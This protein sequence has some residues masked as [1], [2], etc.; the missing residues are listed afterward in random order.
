MGLEMTELI[1]ACEEEFGVDF[2][3]HERAL[4]NVAT[5]GDL[6]RCIVSILQPCVTERCPNVPVFLSLRRALAD[7]IPISKSDIGLDTKLLD[8]LSARDW[9]QK[10]PA[11]RESLNYELPSPYPIL[12]YPPLVLIVG[13][14]LFGALALELLLLQLLLD[15]DTWEPWYLL[16]LLAPLLLPL[17]AVIVAV[18]H[19]L[20]PIKYRMPAE[21]V[22]ELVGRVVNYNHKGLAPEG[23]SWNEASVLN[24][25]R[26]MISER[27]FVDVDRITPET[28]FFKDLGFG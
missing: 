17:V 18:S 6:H 9:F 26:S 23:I 12:R 10:W 2:R 22:R 7:N 28:D 21:T 14:G 3:E 24:E 19:A 5:V 1:M 13:I 4:N 27:F 20:A 25:L 16:V 11:L 8:H 15:V